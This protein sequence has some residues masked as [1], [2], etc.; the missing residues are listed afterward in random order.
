MRRS[1]NTDTRQRLRYRHRIRHGKTQQRIR[2]VGT[3]L[4]TAG[5]SEEKGDRA[6]QH[7][8]FAVGIG[9]ATG[10]G[11]ALERSRLKGRGGGGIP[12]PGAAGEASMHARQVACLPPRFARLVLGARARALTGH[13]LRTGP[14]HPRPDLGRGRVLT[15]RTR[16][17]ESGSRRGCNFPVRPQSMPHRSLLPSNA[18]PGSD[19]LQDARYGT[20]TE[21]TGLYSTESFPEACPHQT[22][23]GPFRTPREGT[24]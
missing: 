14:E 21:T 2:C 11:I 4:G 5:I 24:I 10:I 6:F 22:A 8:A 7:K 15:T 19:A 18:P 12:P 23:D 3:G 1:G 20:C 16:R 13:M 9:T 17:A